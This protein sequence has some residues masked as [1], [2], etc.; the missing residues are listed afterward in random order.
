MKTDRE[1]Q[2]QSDLGFKVL[3]LFRRE[4]SVSIDKSSQSIFE[5]P[6]V[7]QKTSRK[8]QK[9]PKKRRLRSDTECFTAFC[10]H[11]YSCQVTVSNPGYVVLLIYGKMKSL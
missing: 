11:C 4:L 6:Q 1:R 3:L 8:C 5:T 7:R 10:M 2:F 9:Q